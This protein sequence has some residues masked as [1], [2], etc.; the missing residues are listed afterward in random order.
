MAKTLIDRIDLRL[1]KLGKTDRGAS[2]EATGKPDL[3]RQL[4]KQRVSNPRIDTM[5]KLAD[6]LLTTS[7]WLIDGTGPEEIEQDKPHDESQQ[8]VHFGE[9]KSQPFFESQ[10]SHQVPVMGKAAGSILGATNI[11]EDPIEFINLPIA[12][13]TIR[14]I[15]ALW[16]EGTSMLE[17]YEPGEPI[18]V[19]P[20]RTVRT[21]DFVVVQVIQDGELR[22]LVKRFISRDEE[23]VKLEQFNPKSFIEI[24][25]E[26]IHAI[27][28]ILSTPELIGLSV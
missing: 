18:I 10:T 23:R 21:N 2:M 1:K 6:T 25:H 15:Y 19:A 22:A 5:K 4:R 20:H 7:E 12:T 17:K 27:H 11:A 8:P 26:Q 13:A 3:V 28:R 16:V 24:P 14:D 9:D